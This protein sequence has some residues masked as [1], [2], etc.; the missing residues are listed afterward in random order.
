MN[1]M[2][3]VVKGNIRKRSVIR[4]IWEIGEIRGYK[5]ND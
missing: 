5:E 2:S 1:D 3:T 4:E